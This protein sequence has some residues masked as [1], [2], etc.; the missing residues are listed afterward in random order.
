MANHGGR[1]VGSGRKPSAE[2]KRYHYSVMLTDLELTE[3]QAAAL[4]AYK[5]TST[6]MRET[7]LAAALR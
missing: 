1:R 2:P 3:I 6:W 5:P 4:R 7:C